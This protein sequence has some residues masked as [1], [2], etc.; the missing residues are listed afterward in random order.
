MIPGPLDK[1]INPPKQMLA[2]KNVL[3]N[4]E[5]RKEWQPIPNNL[6]GRRRAQSST[7]AS[8]AIFW[9][10]LYFYTSLVLSACSSVKYSPWEIQDNDLPSNQ[11]AVNLEKLR[12][13]SEPPLE[14]PFKI[15]VIGDPQGTPLDFKKTI[16]SINRLTDI[17]FILILGDITDHGLLHEFEWAFKA[18]EASNKPWFTAIGNHDGLAFGPEIYQNIFG[19]LDYRFEYSG[20]RFL[21]WN[22]NVKEFNDPNFKWLRE[23]FAENRTVVASHIP[24]VLDL[25]N[26]KELDE[27]DQMYRDFS[28]VASLHGH[29]GSTN[30]FKWS[31]PMNPG[32]SLS[33]PAFGDNSEAAIHYFITPKNKGARYSV[34]TF[35]PRDSL[36]VA[37]KRADF[38]TEDCYSSCEALYE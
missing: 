19:P 34:V 5:L 28:V 6:M 30:S 12:Q 4:L 36:S 9:F 37:P 1:S 20:L 32:N 27:W 21:M 33:Q 14:E 29:R 7:T 11:I 26:Q 3:Q 38:S 23:N 24:P 2:I 25:H 15:A 10:L 8:N 31:K 35:Q 16:E 17:R 13:T 18:L 22:N